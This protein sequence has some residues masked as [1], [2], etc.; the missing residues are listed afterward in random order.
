MNSTEK[1]EAVIGL[2]VHAQLMTK[3]KIFASDDTT[4]GR[5]AN[6]QVSAITLALPGILPKLNK[7]VVEMAIKMGIACH[8]HIAPY[9]IF[10]RKNYFYA[11]SPKG[12]Q[13]SQDKFPICEGG[14]LEISI[15]KLKKSISLTRIHLEEDAGKNNHE[16][17]ENYSM[18]DLNRSGVPLIEIVSDPVIS[19]SEE[20]FAYLYEV[21]KLVRYLGICDGNMEEGSLR[22]DANISIRLKGEKVLNT[23]VE[24]KNMNSLRNV[25]RAID[26]EIKRQIDLVES[27]GKVVQETRSFDA[28]D[29]STF[30]LRSKESAHD[31]R[32]FP[33]PDLPP[34]VISKEKIAEIKSKMPLLPS[35]YLDLFTDKYQLSEQDAMLLTEEKR[36]ADFFLALT[37]ETNNYKSAANWIMGEIK[38]IL[39]DGSA[40]IEQLKVS[41]KI[42][43]E[44]ILLVDENKLNS[45]SAKRIFEEHLKGSK[46]TALEI[47]QSMSLIQSSDKDELTEWIMTAISKNPEKV[48]EYKK[49]RKGILGLFMGDIMKLSGGK[50][51][52]K[53]CTKLLQEFLEK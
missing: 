46:G 12:Y 16:L 43:G 26:G 13:I 27:G 31:Y 10:S 30:S 36:M 15:N 38:S 23:R 44:L 42:I 21:R 25:K 20:A 50:A 35:E 32:Y 47:A 40:Q 11:D 1:Y 4:F 41:P 7:E 8:C 5:S 9:T 2:E 33:E 45:S 29:G 53:L 24:V 52:P 18:I 19:N 14:F 48:I 51:D 39:N 6:T 28:S 34:V 49:G 3:S 22:C 37:K 17:D